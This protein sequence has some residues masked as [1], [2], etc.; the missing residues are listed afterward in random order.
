MKKTIIIALAAGALVAAL[1]I[2]ALASAGR[3]RVTISL[4]TDSASVA[5]TSASSVG[6]NVE[7]DLKKESDLYKLWVANKCTQDGGMFTAEYQPVHDGKASG[8]TVAS[9]SDCTAYVWM[10]P[11]SETPIRGASISYHVD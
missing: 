10:F 6:F 8:F 7:A 11:N 9:G 5:T 3:A 1:A 4:D 2:P